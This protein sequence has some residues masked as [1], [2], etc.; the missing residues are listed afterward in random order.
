M[1]ITNCLNFGNPKKPEV[2]FQFREAVTGMGEACSAL[3]TPVTGGN[4]SFYNESPLGAVYPTPTVGMVGLLEDISHATTAR[5]TTPG[6]AVVLLGA[7]TSEIG[8]SEYLRWIHD[9]V[10]GPPP[11]CDL[12]AERR[13]IDALLEAITAGTVASAHDCSDGGFAVA[14]AECCVM[15]REATFGAS[16]EL[17]APEGVAV[18]ALLFGEA[19]GRVIVSTPDPAAVVSIATRHGVPAA[20]IGQVTRAGGSLEIRIGERHVAAPVERLAEAYHGAIPAMMS[21]VAT[22]TD[23]EEATLAVTR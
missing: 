1:A 7:H 9:T 5:F 20:T 17:V 3:G 23:D 6:H 22:A 18:R 21:R 16:V 15:D 13:L 8:A 10:A 19:Q 11:G 4:V 14:L 2:F 12:D